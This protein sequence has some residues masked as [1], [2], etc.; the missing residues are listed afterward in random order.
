M[1]VRVTACWVKRSVM[2]TRKGSEV[3]KR[4]ERAWLVV[5]IERLLSCG[6]VRLNR[7]PE[8]QPGPPREI[9]QSQMQFNG[10][11]YSG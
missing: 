4:V 1:C 9:G 6:N 2:V 8:K 3:S 5:L 10:T 7:Q 11:F